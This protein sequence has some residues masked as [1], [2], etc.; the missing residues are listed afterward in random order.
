MIL[1]SRREQSLV[2]QSLVS[3][4]IGHKRTNQAFPKGKPMV[5]Y[6]I[7][8]ITQSSMVLLSHCY[9]ELEN[10]SDDYGQLL[11]VNEYIVRIKCAP[12]NSE[13]ANVSR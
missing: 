3:E 5:F 9:M 10:R 12:R 1:S 6:I 7:M 4:G 2:K 8:C 11:T 13:T